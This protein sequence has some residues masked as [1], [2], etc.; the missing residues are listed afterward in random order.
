MNNYLYKIIS[1]KGICSYNMQIYYHKQVNI[2]CSALQ[3]LDTII[4]SHCDKYQTTKTKIS[5]YL[6]PITKPEIT[7]IL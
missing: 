2:N 1:Y 4:D 7:L 5:I 3:Q 6:E